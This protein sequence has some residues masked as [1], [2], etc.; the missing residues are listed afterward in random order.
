M[1][2]SSISNNPPAPPVQPPQQA[3]PVVRDR[4]GDKDKDATESKAAKAQESGSTA[5]SLPV[6]P[7]RGR[8]LNISA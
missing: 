4:D 6:D 8:N 3:Q 1:S 7:N 5:Q 2:T